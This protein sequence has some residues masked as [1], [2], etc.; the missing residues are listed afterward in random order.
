M[1][2]LGGYY[3]CPR[4]EDEYEELQYDCG[5]VIVHGPEEE[6]RSMKGGDE[7]KYSKGF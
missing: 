6:R 5:D 7:L 3:G 1:N 2:I 4:M